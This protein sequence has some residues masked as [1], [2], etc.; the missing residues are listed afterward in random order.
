MV[1]VNE[2]SYGASGGASCTSVCL[3]IAEGLVTAGGVAALRTTFATE[4][5]VAT[6]VALGI[7][8]DAFGLTVDRDLAIGV[9]AT[10][11]VLEIS[12]EVISFTGGVG[13]CVRA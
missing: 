6:A 2:L 12:F 3:R 1:G 11:R 13:L 5:R 4:R 9:D 10:T 7:R 8:V